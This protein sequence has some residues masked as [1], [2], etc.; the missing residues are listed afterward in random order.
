MIEPIFLF[1]A[2]R[3]RLIIATFLVPLWLCPPFS[4]HHHHRSTICLTLSTSYTNKKPLNQ[5][6]QTQASP[7]NSK[8]E[9][10]HVEQFFGG[11]GSE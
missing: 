9:P 6:D 4:L 1:P 10:S 2:L 5:D 7:L 11:L 8:G 3:K